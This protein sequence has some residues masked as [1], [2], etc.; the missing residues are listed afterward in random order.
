MPRADVLTLASDL[1]KGQAEAIPTEHYYD[2]AMTV[3]AQRPLFT[4]AELVAVTNG[5]AVYTRPAATGRLMGM[6]YDDGWLPR[7]SMDELNYLDPAWRDR[8]GRPVGYVLEE[9]NAL[10]IRLYPTPDVSSTAFSFPSGEPLG[11]DYPRYALVFVYG[12][13]RDNLPAWMDLPLALG[14]LQREF[15]RESNHR[16][17]RF[18]D[19]CGALSNLF[20][21]LLL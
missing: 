2:E 1:S 13:R 7:L 15:S 17:P 14:V 6:L 10:D 3:L 11:V 5:T 8:I 12:E 4:Q 18:A 21:G 9:E 16:D 20:M 19:A